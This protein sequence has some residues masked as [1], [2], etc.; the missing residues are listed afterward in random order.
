MAGATGRL[1]LWHGCLWLLET[2]TD[3]LRRPGCMGGPGAQA[4]VS[5]VGSLVVLRCLS[6]AS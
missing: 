3:Y 4:D 1:D 5:E 2:F 6:S